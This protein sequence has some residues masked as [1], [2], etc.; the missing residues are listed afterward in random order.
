V[1]EKLSVRLLRKGTSIVVLAVVV[2]ALGEALPAHASTLT[3]SFSS[4]TNGASNSV[5]Q[6]YMDSV[7]KGVGSVTVKGSIASNSYTGDSH[8]VGP[9][10][11]SKYTSVTLANSDGTFI[12][13]DTSKGSNEI[14]MTF[15][16]LKIYSVTF[17]YEIFPDGTCANGNKDKHGHYI[18]CSSWPDFTFDADK[19][20]VF[21]TLGVMP[22]NP[23]APWPD[24][25]AMHNGE[26]APQY[27]GIGSLNSGTV[28]FKNGVS[29]LQFIDWPAAIGI[30]NLKIT[31]TPAPEPGVVPLLGL[32]LLGVGG[33]LRRRLGTRNDC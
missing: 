16:G 28:T 2:L 9:I 26:T 18:N 14:D 17:D 19:G 10:V 3:F 29:Y 11:K 22:G 27:L 4:L 20:L 1:D 21:E 12:M 7:L 31:T 33:A 24:S 6:N 32:T 8:V 13:N 25:P 23:G 15:T 30:D 5:V